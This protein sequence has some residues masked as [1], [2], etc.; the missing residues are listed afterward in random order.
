MKNITKLIL[1]CSLLAVS[2]G[3]WANENDAAALAG[4]SIKLA[5]NT[6]VSKGAD[7]ELSR[8][9][10]DHRNLKRYKTRK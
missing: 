4:E 8:L 2:L 9:R 10:I 5:D 3:S 7:P 1:S 6:S